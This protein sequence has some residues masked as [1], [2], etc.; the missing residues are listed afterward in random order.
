MM[1]QW[2]GEGEDLWKKKKS[3]EEEWP[4]EKTVRGGRGRRKKQKKRSMKYQAGGNRLTGW[5]RPF[6]ENS[7][8]IL[9]NM[10]RGR[11]KKNMLTTHTHTRRKETEGGTVK[12][13]EEM[14]ND[15]WREWRQPNNA[16]NEEENMKMNMT[17]GESNGRRRSS[18]NVT[19][20]E[21]ENDMTRMNIWCR[22]CRWKKIYGRLSKL[23]KTYKENMWK[24]N[25][26]GRRRRQKGEWKKA[27]FELICE[28]IKLKE[29]DMT[30][31]DKQ[32]NEQNEDLNED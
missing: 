21:N 13:Y 12:K 30:E 32:Y 11:M 23:S 19:E 8:I 14:R 20:R 10:K 5:D 28:D 25:D 4:V 22:A 24:E 31:N 1:K 18:I 29:N 17:R 2:T 16:M 6:N 26:G 9:M 3:G 27:A 15:I 7:E